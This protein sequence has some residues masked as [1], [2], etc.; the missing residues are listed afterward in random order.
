MSPTTP[1]YC[2]PVEEMSSTIS[3][4]ISNPASIT[5]QIQHVQHTQGSFWPEEKLATECIREASPL[6]AGVWGPLTMPE[7]T[8]DVKMEAFWPEHE[9]A[10]KSKKPASPLVAG[11]WGPLTIPEG[12]SDVQMGAFWAE[13]KLPADC[14]DTASP[15]AAGVWGPL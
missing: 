12:T 14:V 3:D 10:P 2:G 8:S 15:M 5:G 9:L 6:V 7:E 11:V 4:V 13:Q 1:C